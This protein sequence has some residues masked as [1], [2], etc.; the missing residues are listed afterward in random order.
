L[1]V[2]SLIILLSDVNP[3]HYYLNKSNRGNL[4]VFTKKVYKVIGIQKFSS[5]Y[6]IEQKSFKRSKRQVTSSDFQRFKNSL[7]GTS[8]LYTT[9][10]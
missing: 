6:I 5:V 1:R 10:T 2:K 4:I 9:Y 3:S 8:L 7:S